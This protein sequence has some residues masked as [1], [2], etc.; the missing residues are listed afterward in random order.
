MKYPYVLVACTPKA[1]L[2]SEMPFKG[3]AGGR[4]G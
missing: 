4:G 2:A 1:Y 3:E